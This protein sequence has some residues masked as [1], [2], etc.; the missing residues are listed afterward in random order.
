MPVVPIGIVIPVL[1]PSPIPKPS[2]SLI[3]PIGIVI[4]VIP[5]LPIPKPAMSIGGRPLPGIPSVIPPLP[6]VSIG[7]VVPVL[8]TLPLPPALTCPLDESPP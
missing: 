4:P 3:I 8:P 6:V 7:I 5:T 2:P 1:P